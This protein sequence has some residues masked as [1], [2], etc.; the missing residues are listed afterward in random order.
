MPP[1]L[2]FR[3]RW[4]PTGERE[5]QAEPSMQIKWTDTDPTT[6]QRRFLCAEK[7][8]GEWTFRSKLVRRGEWTRGLEPTIEMWEHVLSSL[9]RRYRRR[10]GVSDEDIEQV[11]RILREL[12]ERERD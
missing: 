4:N 3:V 9:H 1:P 2:A 11:E 8:A 5:T 10:E 6:G 12:Y 7:F